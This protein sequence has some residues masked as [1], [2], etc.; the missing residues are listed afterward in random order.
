VTVVPPDFHESSPTCPVCG[1]D[2][3]APCVA[4]HT[5]GPHAGPPKG[6]P[7]KTVHDARH[8]RWR[9][10]FASAAKRQVTPRDH[11]PRVIAAGAIVR[12]LAGPFEGRRASVVSVTD[13]GA[14][15]RRPWRCAISVRFED[16]QTESFNERQVEVVPALRNGGAW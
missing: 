4:I 9:S 11:A 6:Q 16:G 3:G 5:R 8:A 15:R 1:A 14:V 13:F 10:Q 12:V 7:V 2:V